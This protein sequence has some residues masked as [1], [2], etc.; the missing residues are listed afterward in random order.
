MYRVCGDSRGGGAVGALP[1]GG[2]AV[3]VAILA[4]YVESLWSTSIRGGAA[5]GGPPLA[6]PVPGAAHRL[7]AVS[8]WMPNVVETHVEEAEARSAVMV[9]MLLQAEVV[10][11]VTGVQPMAL[12]LEYHTC[13]S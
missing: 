4:S 1:A 12:K 8:T 13:K 11:D 2:G 9:L 3:Q 5:G 6:A 7:K 10:V